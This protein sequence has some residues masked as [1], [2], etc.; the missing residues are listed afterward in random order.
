MA[1]SVTGVQICKEREFSKRVDT[2]VHSGKRIT[3]LDCHRSELPAFNTETKTPIFLWSEE[4][5]W[6][7]LGD[8][9]FYYPTLKLFLDLEL[10]KFAISRT[11]SVWSRTKRA[12]SGYEFH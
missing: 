7:S 8:R 2:L 9:M 6:D 11:C 1:V 4:D 10:F 12:S 3:V 5:R